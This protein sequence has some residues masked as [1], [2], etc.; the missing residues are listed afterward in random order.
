MARIIIESIGKENASK[1]ARDQAQ[2]SAKKSRFGGPLSTPSRPF[3]SAG[4]FVGDHGKRVAIRSVLLDF[5]NVIAFFD[6]HKACRQL[7]AFST[8]GIDSDHIYRAIFEGG[9]EAGY[10]TGRISTGEFIQQLRRTFYLD[11]TDRQIGQAWSDIFAPNDGMVSTIAS[12]KA[13][14][15]RLVLAS[16]TN[17]L[18][19]EWFAQQFTASLSALD[20]EVVSYRVG[21]RKPERPF[22]DAC[23]AA[24][25]CP[26][27]ECLYVDDRHDFVAAGR[28][29]GLHGLVYTP[30][31]DVLAATC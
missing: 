15:L 13:R 7:A 1:L 14:G 8:V 25:H 18:H 2:C 17:A 28:A 31:V 5:G 27:S 3:P 24:A 22:F 12:L 4:R 20:A 9:V 11:A 21:S 16:N 23:I 29:L 26:P 10:D 19:H 6:H 30:G